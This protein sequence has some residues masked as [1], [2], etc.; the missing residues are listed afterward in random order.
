MDKS[1]IQE[2]IEQFIQ[3]KGLSVS[4]FEKTVGLSNG[5]VR[6][7]DKGMSTDKVMRIS[8]VFPDLNILWLITGNGTMLT[9]DTATSGNDEDRELLRQ[10]AQNLQ[11]QLDVQ[12]RTIQDLTEQNKSLMQI[13]SSQLEL[14]KQSSS[15]DTA[16]TSIQLVR[17]KQ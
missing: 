1:P 10:L 2:R 7:M 4:R 12:S 8:D 11:N 6:N 16:K 13:I 5:F 14:M 17:E 15:Q 9:T 3:C